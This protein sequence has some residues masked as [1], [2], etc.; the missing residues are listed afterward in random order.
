MGRPVRSLTE[1]QKQ[2]QVMYVHGEKPCHSL[3]NE[4]LFMGR[5]MP[6]VSH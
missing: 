2:M 3:T 5:L 4:L 6:L 1:Q